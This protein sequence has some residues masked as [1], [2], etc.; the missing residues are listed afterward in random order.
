MDATRWQRLARIY[1]AVENLGPDLRDRYLDEACAGDPPLRTEIEIL[2]GNQ[3]AADRLFEQPALDVVARAVAE[4]GSANLGEYP[5][6]KSLLHYDLLEKVGAGGTGVVYRARDTRLNRQVAIKVLPSILVEDKQTLAR[7][8]REAMMMAALDHPGIAG[9]YGLEQTERDY[10]LAMEWVEGE[11]LTQFLRERT[12]GLDEAL[13]ICC[14][15]AEGLETAHAHGI[16]HRDLKPDNIKVT[17]EGKAKILDLGLAKPMRDRPARAVLPTAPSLLD[18]ISQP[19][20][21]LGTPAYMSPEQILGEEVDAGTDIWG[22]GC[23]LYECLTGRRAFRGSDFVEVRTAILQAD[24]DWNLVPEDTPEP[25]RVLMRRCLQKSPHRRLR[26]MAHA[27]QELGAALDPPG[28][29]ERD[30]GRKYVNVRR[31][32]LLALAAALLVLAASVV[33]LLV[34]R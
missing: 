11:L 4:S 1:D 17:P 34:S 25:I 6:G 8:K 29:G 30:G 18:G 28:P 15:I 31:A 12:L 27:R 23:V 21:V 9:I 7:F 26:Q 22:F 2:L 32:I 10:F 19:G 24:P 14:E 13:R 16:L 5:A 33:F 20:F 3:E